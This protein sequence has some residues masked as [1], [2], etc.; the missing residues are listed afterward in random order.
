MSQPLVHGPP[1]APSASVE[2]AFPIDELRRLL[3][4]GS[5]DEARGLLESLRARSAPHPELDRWARLLRPPR[6]RVGGEGRRSSYVAENAAWL[7]E[8][9]EAYHGQWVALD[10]GVLLGANPDRLELHRELERRGVLADALF[11]R[12]TPG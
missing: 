9:S 7:R 1:P 6:A 12:L 2:G 11:F 5:L 10:K 4:S 3:Q 8:N